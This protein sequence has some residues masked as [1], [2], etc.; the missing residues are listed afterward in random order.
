MHQV[1]SNTKIFNKRVCIGKIF[2]KNNLGRI[3]AF[4]AKSVKLE[5]G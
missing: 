5:V 1:F 3:F 2:N 4:S